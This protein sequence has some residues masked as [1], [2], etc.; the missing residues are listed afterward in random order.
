MIVRVKEPERPGP[1]KSRCEGAPLAG[2]LPEL[3]HPKKERFKGRPCHVRS[4]GEPPLRRRPAAATEFAIVG[5]YVI[6]H[7]LPAFFEDFV[8]VW[9]HVVTVSGRAPI[10]SDKVGVID[11]DFRIF[12]VRGSRDV[13][14]AACRQ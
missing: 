11:S 14:P 1:R 9:V 12:V 5:G 3:E 4:N 6:Q 2:G 13:V 10:R 8:K 7:Y